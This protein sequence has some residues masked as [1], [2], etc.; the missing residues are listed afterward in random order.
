MSTQDFLDDMGRAQ[1]QFHETM[2]NM[3][4]GYAATCTPSKLTRLNLGIH[5]FLSGWFFLLGTV[6]FVLNRHPIIAG[7]NYGCGIVWVFLTRAQTRIKK[8]DVERRIEWLAEADEQ[9]QKLALID[10]TNP[11]VTLIIEEEP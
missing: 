4:E 6:Q 5:W 2:I 11:H 7:I 1:V 3:Y 10:P 8:K 9:R